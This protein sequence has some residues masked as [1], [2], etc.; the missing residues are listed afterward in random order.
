MP[1]L[2]EVLVGILGPLLLVAVVLI[3]FLGSAP[4]R[5]GAR[6]RQTLPL[7]LTALSAYI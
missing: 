3:W 4:S 1:A 6:L 7:P 5:P 2:I